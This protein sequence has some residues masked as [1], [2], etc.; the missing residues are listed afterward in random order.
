MK[1]DNSNNPSFRDKKRV[2]TI[3]Q[4][5]IETHNITTDA[6]SSKSMGSYSNYMILYPVINY[7]PR[8]IDVVD[9]AEA[10][11]FEINAMND[12]LERANQAKNSRA[13]QNLPRHLRRRAASHNV[14]RLPIRLRKKATEEMELDKSVP[15]KPS[16]RKQRRPATLSAEYKRRQT[17]KKWLETHMWHSK[18][19]KM[20]ELWGYKLAEHPN[21]KSIKASYRASEHLSIIHDASYFGWL[22]VSGN[23]SN[24]IKLL[25]SVTDPTLPS[26][27][28]ESAYQEVL[29]A[30]EFAREQMNLTESVSIENLQDEFLIFEL[31]GPR[32]TALLQTVLD[33]YDDPIDLTEENDKMSSKLRVNN[34]AHKTWKTLR[35]LRTSTSLPPN[36]V[37]GL[38][39]LD[40][41]LQFPK[42]VPQRSNLMPVESERELQEILVNWP[43]N[44][45]YSELWSD[46][47]RNA[48]SNKISDG[49]LDKRRSKLLVPGQKLLLQS[50]DSLIPIFLI[51]RDGINMSIT[52]KRTSEFVGG[53]NI[54]MP[55]NWGMA[56][57][58]SF[59]FAGAWVG[60]LRER[61]NHHFESG[62]PCFPYDFP[63]TIPYENFSNVQKRVKQLE[64][65]KRPPAKRPN[66]KKLLVD[67][68][69]E[70]PF[71]Q[72]VGIDS[73]ELRDYIHEKIIA[74]EQ[75][76]K[77]PWLLQG[78]KN[79]RLLE[80]AENYSE[81][82]SQLLSKQIIQ[83]FNVRDINLESEAVSLDS[84]KALVHV[85]VGFLARGLP[86][87][88]AII[89]KADKITY[90]HWINVLNNRNDDSN[91]IESENDDTEGVHPSSLPSK[92]DIIGYVT[93]GQFSF[94]QGHG[95]AIG[96]CSVTSILNLFR[97]QKSEGRK[98]TNFVLVRK[99]TSH[100][101]KPAIL[102]ILP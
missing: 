62:I 17:N 34:E 2:K 10:R 88:N 98:I 72:L 55:A 14:K 56:F 16:R 18:R 46:E 40:P 37:L 45:A 48:L 97:I 80:N 35:G 76:K 29:R 30:F 41:R 102:E 39:V 3:A 54:I 79:I 60:G 4:R 31:T 28:S 9:F 99:I 7:T 1:R 96:C 70:P 22:K 19:M 81:E 32:S 51:K 91:S 64:Y 86:G 49:D 74:K 20:T 23:S 75:E 82:F 8:T 71:D 84:S 94:S 73:I 100:T 43:E 5:T 21:E 101:C 59:I 26:V 65:N 87:P 78:I 92:A 77:M 25:N 93:T 27:G 33:L 63:G 50:E 44:V 83:A 67:S 68:P 38:T 11:A 36:I 85:R 89:Y 47:V 13:S 53:W 66:F 42:K 61:H 57:W 90:D 15:K 58:K 12:A 6:G 52:S 95:F 69:F 24:I